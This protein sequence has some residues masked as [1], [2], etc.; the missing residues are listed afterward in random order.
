M[1]PSTEMRKCYCCGRKMKGLVVL[2]PRWCNACAAVRNLRK[3]AEV[4]AWIQKEGF[5]VPHIL[6]RT[7]RISLFDRLEDTGVIN[8]WKVTNRRHH[9]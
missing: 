7:T 2:N 5:F 9:K 8:A 6:S 4:E 1:K 3:L